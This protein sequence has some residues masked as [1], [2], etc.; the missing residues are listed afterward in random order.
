M[1]N[2][3]VRS[4]RKNGWNIYLLLH[5]MVFIVIRICTPY[6]NG[7][8][9]D[10]YTDMYYERRVLGINILGY[11][12]LLGPMCKNMLTST[13]AISCG[14]HEE[15]ILLM[16]KNIICRAV[17][18]SFVLNILFYLIVGTSAD[19]WMLKENIIRIGLLFLTQL[20]GWYVTGFLYVLL[21][22][23]SGNVL[24]TACFS[25]LCMILLHLSN[26]V[27]CYEQLQYYIRLYYLMFHI[28]LYPSFSY[29]ISAVLLYFIVGLLLC[30]ASYKK[31]QRK[32]YL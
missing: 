31:L 3:I 17:S 22:I 28:E 23:C 16:V 13:V 21:Y 19:D 25:Y 5:I 8:V 18:Y 14:N 1:I 9:L 27:N 24:L 32:E 26:Y 4:A 11:L 12:L 30:I 10:A 29:L 20:I 2:V 15:H 6:K 7:M